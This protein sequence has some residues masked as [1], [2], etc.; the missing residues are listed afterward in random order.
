MGDVI[1]LLADNPHRV[2]KITIPPGPVAPKRTHYSS[3]RSFLQAPSQLFISSPRTVNYF[4]QTVPQIPDT[5]DHLDF[6]VLQVCGPAAMFAYHQGR[7]SC[8]GDIIFVGIPEPVTE[9]SVYYVGHKFNE[10]RHNDKQDNK[11]Y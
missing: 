11:I 2:L 5:D 3:Y 9:T 1:Q 8:F 4:S 6:D 10:G 7:P